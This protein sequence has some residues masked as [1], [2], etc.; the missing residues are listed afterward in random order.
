MSRRSRLHVLCVCFSNHYSP[1]HLVW[2]HCCLSRGSTHKHTALF[3]FISIVTGGELNHRKL[4]VWQD[5]TQHLS[6]SSLA[7][8]TSSKK[9]KYKKLC[10]ISFVQSHFPSAPRQTRD[11]AGTYQKLVC[12]IIYLVA[13]ST[14]L[15]SSQYFTT[16]VQ[17][18]ARKMCDCRP[19]SQPALWVST[20]PCSDKV[21]L[22]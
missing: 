20:S 12:K 21:L 15:T 19:I 22:K 1:L 3:I 16:V 5:K 13:F 14:D 11:P 9:K 7:T 6:D 8:H 18:T 10:Q 4:G 2:P 17:S